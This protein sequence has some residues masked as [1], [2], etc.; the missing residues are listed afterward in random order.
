[1]WEFIGPMVK[2]IQE[3]EKRIS[4]LEKLNGTTKTS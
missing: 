4:E 3:L 2:A 1:M